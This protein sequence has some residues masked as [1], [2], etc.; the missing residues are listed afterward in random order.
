M[1]VYD[2]IFWRIAYDISYA[3]M[4]MVELYVKLHPLQ[5]DYNDCLFTGS[6]PVSSN[7]HLNSPIL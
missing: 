7:T 3:K 4:G 2:E 6:Q 5:S 1:P